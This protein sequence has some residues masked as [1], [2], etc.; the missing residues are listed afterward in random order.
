[1]L[2][3]AA[4]RMARVGS[5]L[6]LVG[7]LV[8]CKS[9]EPGAPKNATP[10]APAAKTGEA[11][12]PAFDFATYLRREFAPLPVMKLASGVLT[13]DVEAAS[14]PRVTQGQGSIHVVIPVGTQSNVDCYVYDEQ[15]DGAAKMVQVVEEVKKT[16]D[17]RLFAPT[18]V[19]MAGEIAAFASHA[20]Y[21]I[22]KDGVKGTGE[23]KLAFY[24]HPL[25]PTLCMQDEAGYSASFKR[26]TKRFF[27]TERRSDR[28]LT[29]KA[30]VSW[31]VSVMKLDGRPIGFDEH[32]S[33]EDPANRKKSSI[34]ISSTLYARSP[35]ALRPEDS[36][37]TTTVD[38]SGE[39]LE[40]MRIVGSGQDIELRVD[41]KRVGPAQYAYSGQQSGKPISG[42]FKTKDKLGLATSKRVSDNVKNQLLSGKAPSFKLEEYA[43]GV[44]P[45]AAL[46]TLYEIDSK[47]AKRVRISFGPLTMTAIVDEEGDPEKVDMT[48]G[49]ATLTL[50]RLAAGGKR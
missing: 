21:V 40:Y 14:A 38:A 31:E 27:E 12:K 22:D 41:L 24:H 5:L 6:A 18:D 1:M 35:I 4:M 17:V 46:E 33:Y 49:S 37:T 36:A 23:L 2:S 42:K 45:T 26:V 13:A 20:I 34:S 29:G 32:R 28:E 16:V 50:E 11:A 8:G 48:L 43:P 39:L 44:D 9:P 19:Y 3:L 7:A 47:E 25:T 10:A 15:P 30:P